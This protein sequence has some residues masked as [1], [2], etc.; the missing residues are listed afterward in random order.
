MRRS[1]TIL[2]TVALGAMLAAGSATESMARGGGGGGGFAGGHGGGS[3]AVKSGLA[4]HGIGGRGVAFAGH[5]TTGMSRG[6][7]HRVGTVGHHYRRG[8]RRHYGS[9]FYCGAP[10]PYQYYN[11]ASPYSYDPYCP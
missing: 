10:Y 4:S 1:T 6:V 8:Y 2:M 11:P 9:D 7:T 3:A 5:H